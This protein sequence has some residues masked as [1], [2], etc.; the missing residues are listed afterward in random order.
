LTDRCEA[1]AKLTGIVVP[2]VSEAV[3]KF[4]VAIPVSALA[5]LRC[6]RGS[7]NPLAGQGDGRRL[8]RRRALGEDEGA[9]GVLAIQL[10]HAPP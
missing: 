8:V 9:Y 6:E 7:R 2:L 1:E 3:T 10:R 4:R 5:D